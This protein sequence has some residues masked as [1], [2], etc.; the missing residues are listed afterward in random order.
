[1]ESDLNPDSHS[2]EPLTFV[3]QICFADSWDILPELPGDLLV[4]LARGDDYVNTIGLW[5]NLDD[6]P[7]LD[8]KR[9]PKSGIAL[10][11]LHASLYRTIEYA[12][13]PYGEL[14]SNGLRYSVPLFRHITSTKI[15]GI[16]PDVGGEY[17]RNEGE[18]KDQYDARCQRLDAQLQAKYIGT[19]H[20]P[21]GPNQPYPY[22]GLANGSKLSAR[23]RDAFLHIADCGG[24]SF[25]L[26]GDSVNISLN[27]C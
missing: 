10:L 13:F 9:V 19:L 23:G 3:G 17:V 18:T 4:L 7:L 12:K 5:F 24:L 16:T 25:Y 8:P 26:E 27:S 11:P 1:L 14:K 20:S 2:R 6:G 21:E 15:G 22:I